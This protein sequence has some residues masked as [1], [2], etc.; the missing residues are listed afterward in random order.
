MGRASTLAILTL[1]GST[2]AWAAAA[3]TAAPVT[4]I[5]PV[6]AAN[7]QE[8]AQARAAQAERQAA[9]AQARAARQAA[10]AQQPGSSILT[11][12]VSQSIEA[13]SN[14]NLD[15]DSPGT[16]YLGDT[17]FGL[18]LEQ[19]TQSHDL[20]LGFDTALRALDEADEEFE[21]TL[22]SP[23][24]ALLDYDFTG[25]RANFDTLL[26][27]RQRRTDFIDFDSFDQIGSEDD[28]AVIRNE[29]DT[30]EHR[31]DGELGVELATDSPSTYGLRWVGTDISYSDDDDDD[32][33]TPRRTNQFTGTWTLQVT[34]VFSSIL[35]AEHYRYEADNDGE[36]EITISEIDAGIVYEPDENLR[37]RGG[38]GYADRQRDEVNDDN[39]QDDQGPTVR[40]DI[41]YLTDD[42]TL[43][44]DAR[45]TTAAPDPRLSFNLNAN[46]DLARGVLRGRVFNRYTG[47][48]TDGNEI[49]VSGISIGLEQDFNTVS[50]YGIDFA[51]TNRDDVDDED[52]P[53]TLT[54][55]VT[56]RYIHNL[57]ETVTA[58]LGYRYRA[59]TEDDPDFDA[60]SHRVFFTIG[61]TF[62]TGL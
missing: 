6:E 46:Y 23:T 45:Y 22:G 62:Q 56:A 29:D 43:I 28:P 8:L 4:Q 2:A 5:T 42:L 57:T 33:L 53:D 1:T 51:V 54:T 7:A 21:F 20:I 31:L 10:L 49:R 18:I 35:A 27:Y 12:T 44:G 25:P 39:D 32:N 11:A 19:N 58:E 60:D 48:T 36:T 47:A 40:G 50:G 24:G 14:Y 59:E 3:Q 26:S 41:R 15:E 61:K 55:S 52:D 17:R 30:R 16:T 38:V 37:L 13:D 9:A 34:P